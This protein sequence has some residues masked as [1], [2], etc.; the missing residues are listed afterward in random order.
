MV[1]PKEV[2]KSADT[3]QYSDQFY[4][5]LMKKSYELDVRSQ[6]SGLN[7]YLGREITWHFKKDMGTSGALARLNILEKV[8]KTRCTIIR[9]RDDISA[10]MERNYFDIPLSSNPILIIKPNQTD[11]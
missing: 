11:E 5:E 4:E 3:K 10:M 1:S 6:G 2:L 8:L 9:G 7:C